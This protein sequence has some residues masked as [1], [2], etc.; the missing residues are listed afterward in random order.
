[1]SVPIAVICTRLDLVFPRTVLL[2]LVGPESSLQQPLCSRALQSSRRIW[3]LS[4]AHYQTS[5]PEL[6]PTRCGRW[7]VYILL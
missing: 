5:H 2:D 1:M 6:L 4:N 3:V 7:A